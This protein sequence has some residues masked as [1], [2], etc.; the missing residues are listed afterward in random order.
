MDSFVF[1]DGE[2]VTGLRCPKNLADDDAALVRRDLDAKLYRRRKRY[3][4]IVRLL[5]VVG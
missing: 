2:G 3:P 5:G 1:A 4:A